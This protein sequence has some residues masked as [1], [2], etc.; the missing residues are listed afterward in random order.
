MF[1]YLSPKVA[2]WASLLPRPESSSP[3]PPKQANK[4]SFNYES[5][6]NYLTLLVLMLLNKYHVFFV[7][8]LIFMFIIF[9]VDFI[10][11][12][13]TSQD[14]DQTLFLGPYSSF[15]AISFNCFFSVMEATLTEQPSTA[16]PTTVC[17]FLHEHPVQKKCGHSAQTL[18]PREVSKLPA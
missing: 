14:L 17:L 3:Y 5:R 10:S 6:I 18:P 12:I 8:S 7:L 13:L 11:T 15:P 9:W 16:T 1:F 2:W 4:K